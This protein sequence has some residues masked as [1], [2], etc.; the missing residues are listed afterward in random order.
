MVFFDVDLTTKE[1]KTSE[2]QLEQPRLFTRTDDL[3]QK[4]E[5]FQI[6][7]P[8]HTYLNIRLARILT[9]PLCP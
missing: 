2:T 3:P 8:L 4:A 1:M 9:D 7:R 6:R 5:S